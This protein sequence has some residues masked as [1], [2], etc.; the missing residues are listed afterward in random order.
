MLPRIVLKNYFKNT[1]PE[2]TTHECFKKADLK[3]EAL[4]TSRCLKAV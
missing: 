3:P 1:V 2:T 4:S